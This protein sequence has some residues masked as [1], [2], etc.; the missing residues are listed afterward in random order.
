MSKAIMLASLPIFTLA[1]CGHPQPIPVSP[2]V[3][4]CP[5]VA[6]PPAELMIPPETDFLPPNDS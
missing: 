5:P 2:K 1:S 3:Q 6:Q 4:Q